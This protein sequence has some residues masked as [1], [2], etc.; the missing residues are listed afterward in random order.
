MKFHLLAL[1]LV[2]FLPA[3][4]TAQPKPAAETT[5]AAPQSPI[6]PAAKALL[7][8][9]MATYK[10]APGIRY[11]VANSVDG[12]D[13][14]ASSLAFSRPNLLSV[15]R[16]IG[17][18]TFRL[19]LDGSDFYVVQGATYRKQPAPPATGTPTLMGGV[20]G[21]SGQLIGAMLDGKNPLDAM[22][23]LYSQ[24]PF[25]NFKGSTVALAPRVVDGD[26]LSGIQSTFS[27]GIPRPDGK[28]GT[29]S[30]QLTAWFGGKPLSLR[31]VQTRYTQNGKVTTISEK[32]LDQQLSPTF[33]E[34]AFKFNDTGLKLASEEEGADQKYWDAR[35]TVGADPFA[36]S[37][38]TLDGK[39]ISL[40]SYKGKVVLLD[41][42]ATW[43]GPCVAAL[44]E[45]QATY[46][47]YHAQG[48]EVVGI[49]FDED[50]GALTSF[51]KDKKM[52]WPQV[53]DG[54]GWGT[55]IGALYGVK[56]IPF[57]LLVG[58][59]G[60]IAAVNPRNDLEGAVK[61]ALAAS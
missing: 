25:Q 39:A 49:S 56:A 24:A 19:L 44:P 30:Q 6:D 21:A 36:F 42:W 8:R 22:Q 31:R 11:R 5:G 60:K 2:A 40:D 58:R 18:E 12:K 53:F 1:P 45:L 16:Q 61:K 47:K 28:V 41:F 33:E 32:I 43:C 26:V 51:I 46:K 50:K 55:E 34:G 52:A 3:C 4:A 38:K 10:D 20:G 48:L 59:D 14:G 13:Q 17:K 7:E 29:I 15:E 23:T 37:T 9:A 57:V 54:K 27:F 35:L